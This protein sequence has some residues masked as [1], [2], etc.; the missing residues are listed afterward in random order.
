MIDYTQLVTKA[1][2]IVAAKK[3]QWEA[4]KAKR[5]AVSANSVAVGSHWFESNQKS[6]MQQ[7]RRAMMGVAAPAVQ[8]KKLDNT[9]VTMTPALAGQ[10]LQ[11]TEAHDTACFSVAESHR[12]AME[13]SADPMAYDYSTGW[14]ASYTP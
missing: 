7:M 13:A 9:F 4:I 2:K 6:R 12:T 3:L 14:P 11:A 10:I 1:D 8:W 5:D